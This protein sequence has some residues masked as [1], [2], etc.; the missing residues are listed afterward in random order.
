VARVRAGIAGRGCAAG[1]LGRPD[2]ADRVIEI[3]EDLAAGR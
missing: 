3:I 1:Q 2:A